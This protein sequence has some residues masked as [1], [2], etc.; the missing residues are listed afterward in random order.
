MAILGK[1]AV[2]TVHPKY[3]PY[4]D[5]DDDSLRFYEAV[6]SKAADASTF[7]ATTNAFATSAHG[8]RQTTVSKSADTYYTYCDI[9]G[10][11]GAMGSIVFPQNASTASGFYTIKLTTDGVVEEFKTLTTS[12]SNNRRKWIGFAKEYAQINDVRYMGEGGYGLHRF[13]EENTGVDSYPGGATIRTTQDMVVQGLPVHLFDTSL[14]VEVK[15]SLGG[16]ANAE[17]G[18]GGVLAYSFPN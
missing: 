2:S 18:Y 10:S 16:H 6:S 15:C 9:T 17:R 7:W 1:Q 5:T 13:Y 12:M 11:H 3:W 8:H 4:C 14:K